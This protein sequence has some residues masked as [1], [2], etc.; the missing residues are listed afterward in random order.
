MLMV[1]DQSGHR[2]VLTGDIAKTQEKEILARQPWLG[3]QSRLGQA[4]QTI[5]VAAHHGSRDSSDAQWL[6]VLKPDWLV[7]QAGYRNRFGHPT[8]PVLDR[9]AVVGSTVLRT[10][11]HGG[12]Q[13]RWQDGQ[14]RV[15]QAQTLARRFWHVARLPAS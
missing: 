6:Q 5:L 14:W 12:V 15:S 4:S 2:L 3:L 9:A 11:L 10:D 13:M 8:R 1:E 7:V